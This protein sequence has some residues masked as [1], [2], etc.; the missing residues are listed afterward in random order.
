MENYIDDGHIHQGH[1]SRMRAK[2]LAHG[3]RIFDTYELLEMLLYQVIPYKDTNP[4]AK[5]LL[6][7]FGGLDGVFRAD[8]EELTTVSGIGERTAEFISRVGLL[9]SIL[10]AEVLSGGQQNF[11]NYE[12][13]GEFFVN[14]FRDTEE[15]CVFAM[16]LDNNMRP[17]E[18]K[19]LF[20]VDYESAGVKAKAFIDAA[21]LNHASVIITAHN[22]PHGPFYPTPGDRATNNAITSSL[23][24]VGLVHAEHYLVCG[25]AYA[26]IGSIKNFINPTRQTPALSEFMDGKK[27]FDALGRVCAVSSSASGDLLSESQRY[28]KRDL[29]YFASLLSWVTGDDGMEIAHKLLT[30]YQTI[31]NVITAS[32]DE[33]ISL[34]TEKLAFYVKL[35]GFITSRRAT[36]LFALGERKS[37]AEISEF[38]KALFIGESVEKIYLLTFDSSERLT[39]CKLLGEGTVS[40]SE[41]LPRKACEAAI[42]SSAASV[43]IAHNHPFGNPEPSSDDVKFTGVFETLFLSCGIKLLGHYIIA[44]HRSKIIMPDLPDAEVILEG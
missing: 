12:T 13:V 30:K 2:L 26:G 9:S 16:F 5:R 36:D 15:N 19:K 38:L 35:L 34:S 31:E 17:I 44:G 24:M 18:M 39:G 27:R 1:R 7:T 32:S 40:S 11:A 23:N 4:I 41:V 29:P 25:D 3:Q 6:L 10:G 43:A 33:I 42:S 20:S 21:M 22:H 28:N 8:R 37:R 14:C